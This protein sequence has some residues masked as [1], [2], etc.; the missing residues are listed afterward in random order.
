MIAVLRLILGCRDALTTVSAQSSLLQ[1]HL[2]PVDTVDAVL[3]TKS[4][5]P[6]VLSLSY[7]SPFRD[8]VFE[9]ACE[10]GVVSINGDTVTVNDEHHDIPFEGRG[11]APEVADFAGSVANGRGVEKRQSPEEALGDL[12]MLEKMLTS[13]EQ[14][15]TRVELSLQ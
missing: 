8:S 10:G 1:T 6:G 4:G 9:F 3:R 5:A 15:G 14:K 12:E 11:V 13:G 2:P 7:G